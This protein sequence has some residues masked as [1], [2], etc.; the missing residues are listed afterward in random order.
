MSFFN[1]LGRSM[2]RAPRP[3]KR[4]TTP[5]SSSF[6]STE[7]LPG[8]PTTPSVPKPLYLCSPFVEAALVKGNFKHIVML[9]KYA[10]VMEWVAVNIFDFYQ[11]LNQFYGVLAE[12]CTQQSCPTMSA[13]PTLN[14]TW[15]NQDRKSVQLPAP[16][17]IDYVMTWVQNLLDDENVFPTKSGRDFSQTFPS[18]VKH[19][20]RQLL[21]VFAHLYHSHYPQILHLR[22]EPHFNSLFAHFLAFGKEYE[23]LDLKDVKGQS[24]A[25]VGIGALWER[26]K[27]MGILE[28]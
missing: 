3:P 23:L 19:V 16:T 15:I 7:S 8:T 1:S 27:E 9:P 22:S 24:G 6:P 21:R 26:W 28:S 11:N 18:T 20:Y 10:D 25:P 14:Y 13:G 2:Q 4:S 12:C 5:T 17:Y